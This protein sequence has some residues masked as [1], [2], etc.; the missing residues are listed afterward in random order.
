[1]AEAR[2]VSPQL[3]RAWGH[4]PELFVLLD[5]DGD[6][7]LDAVSI[8]VEDRLRRARVRASAGPVLGELA[9]L[10]EGPLLST[11]LRYHPPGTLPLRD[12]APAELTRLAR[13]LGV[14]EWCQAPASVPWTP[15]LACYGSVMALVDPEG[16]V[17]RFEVWD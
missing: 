5:L 13:G 14:V 7:N 11:G 8:E 16:V 9:V 2:D 3:R 1:M 15:E 6:S 4:E 17:H 10:P 12:R